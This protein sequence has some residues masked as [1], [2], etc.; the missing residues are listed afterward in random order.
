MSAT[1]D[2]VLNL[3][4]R[5]GSASVNEL[6]EATGVTPVSV[7]HHLSALQ[8]E[9][10][11][12]SVETHSGVGRPKLLYSLTQAALERFP[13]KY[14]RL[15]DRILDEIKSAMPAPMIERMFATIAQDI[16]TDHAAKFEGKPLEEMLGLL[17]EL[18]GEEGFMAAWNK[19]GDAY[20]LTEY[21][22]PYFAIGQRHPE[23]CTIDQ[24]LISRVLDRPVE[25]S[26]CLLN[27][28]QRCVFIIHPKKASEVP[29]ASESTR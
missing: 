9:G 10:L 5:K 8:A 1:R 24:T 22:C 4:R 14:L 7:R 13:T 18:L 19:V 15:T 12:A 21:N 2:E 16:A 23:V 29:Q 11:I 26:T 17:V 27:G 6:A 3:L 28:D 20:H 25:K